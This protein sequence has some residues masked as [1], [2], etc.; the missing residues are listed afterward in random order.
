S[1]G[2]KA[3]SPSPVT[4]ERLA[5]PNDYTPTDEVQTSGGDEGPKKKKLTLQQLR[6]AET[7]NDEEVARKVAAYQ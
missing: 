4:S 3:K 6:A 1:A 7:A 2:E 5:F